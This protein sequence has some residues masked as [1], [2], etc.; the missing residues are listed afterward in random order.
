MIAGC[1]SPEISIV[2]NPGDRDY[3]EDTKLATCNACKVCAPLGA[4]LVYKGVRGCVPFLHG[5]QGCATYI[6]R[7]MISHFREPVDIACSSFSEQD[8]IFGGSRNF[9]V[10]VDNVVEQ[11]QPEMIG[12]ATTCL[13]ETIGENMLGMIRDY[14]LRQNDDAPPLVN[15]STPS[16][17]GT[18]I[19]GFHGAVLA[20]VRQL[21]GAGSHPARADRVNLFPGMLS[22]E[23]LRHLREITG[24][25]GAEAT[26]LPDYSHSLDGV[27]WEDYHKIPSGGTAKEDIAGCPAAR[28]SLEL[29]ATL[30]DPVTKTSAARFLEKEH[31]V[32]RY[33]LPLPIGIRGTDELLNALAAITGQDIPENLGSERGRL[34]D[35][36][37]DGHKYV[38]GSRAAVIGDQDLVLGISSFLGEIGLPVALAASGGKTGC[39]ARHAPEAGKCL[40]GV[41]HE[42]IRAAIKELEPTILIG[43]SKVYPI[44]RELKIPLIRVGF[45]IHDRIG[46]QRLL[47]VGYRGAQRLFDEII[48]TILEDRQATSQVGYSYQ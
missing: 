36:L 21:A 5:S 18:H 25:M 44:A 17:Q 27:T 13:S 30:A 22:P 33:S 6:R 10:G 14:K 24:A 32:A 34:I 8:A 11:Y 26:V 42:Q 20:L 31:G 2:G 28:A 19:D 43:S 3:G 23:D 29:G 15:V 35:S 37:V 7:Y 39:F 12:L 41:D 48:N 46:A 40:E 38:F 45:P 47:H 4:C 16:Y 1:S 9:Q